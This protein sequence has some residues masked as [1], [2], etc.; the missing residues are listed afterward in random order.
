MTDILIHVEISPDGTPASNTGHLL[1][2]ARGLGRPV[3]VAA[4]GPDDGAV[5]LGQALGALGAQVCFIAQ[6]EAATNTIAGGGTEALQAAL[7][8]FDASTVLCASTPDGREVLARLAIRTD[9]RLLLEA[10]T[11]RL[12]GEQLI[13]SHSVFGGN[14]TT[15]STLGS[16]LAL[17]TVASSG[18]QPPAAIDAPE[19]IIETLA[20]N[21]TGCS[22]QDFTQAQS[23]AER[24]ELRGA[25]IVV[26]GGRGL[27]SQE[28]FSLIEDLADS[29]KAGLGA[30]R[31]A[32]DAGYVEQSHQVGQTGVSVSPQLYLAVGIS[33]AIQHLAG[34][35][36]AKRIVAINRDENAPIFSIADFGI[37]GDLFQILPQLTEQIQAK[38]SVS[39]G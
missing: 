33:G 7:E 20:V 38:R 37:V 21:E 9:A 34:M 24:P 13:A 31:A 29:L 14:Y 11:L 23:R 22:L 12:A 16:S 10:Q 8:R 39:A 30:S 1:A 35:Q 2:L 27:A 17:V 36:T 25:Q 15:E 32:V 4:V 3:A 5:P 28:N 18:T 19:I 26:S 6:T